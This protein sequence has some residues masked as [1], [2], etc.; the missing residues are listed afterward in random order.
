MLVNDLLKELAFPDP[1]RL[2][3]QTSD[4]STASPTIANTSTAGSAVTPLNIIALYFVWSGLML[5]LFIWCG[6]TLRGVG[7]SRPLLDA[8]SDAPELNHDKSVIKTPKSTLAQRKQTI[9]ELF[10]TSQVTMVSNDGDSAT[11]RHDENKQFTQKQKAH[12]I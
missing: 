8:R 5:L 7:V 4:Y 2:L 9:L 12:H 1:E 6:I 11:I 10:E 3:E